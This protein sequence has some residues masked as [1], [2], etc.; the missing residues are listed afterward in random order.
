LELR[1]RV[2]FVDAATHAPELHLAPGY[3]TTLTFNTALAPG[4][5]ELEGSRV[6]WALVELGAPTL[7]L[8]PAVELAAGERLALTVRYADGQVPASTT[9][10]LVSHPSEVDA[11]VR[12]VRRPL[13]EELLKAEQAARARC[14][15]GGLA[16]PILSGVVGEGGVTAVRLQE[17]LLWEGLGRAANTSPLL[18]RAGRRMAVAVPVRNPEGLPPWVPA[19]ARLTWLSVEGQPVGP[20]RKLPVHMLTGALAPGASGEVVVEWD[21]PAGQTPKVVSLD[22]TDREGRGVRWSRIEL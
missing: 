9:F 4:G 2:Q 3:T 21:L 17:E 19:E 18:Y 10:A 14:E 11:Q 15:A 12:V 6:R 20:P 5:V 13:S 8:Q 1:Q 7:V 22:I 16:G